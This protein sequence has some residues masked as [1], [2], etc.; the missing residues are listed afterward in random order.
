MVLVSCINKDENTNTKQ[1]N[2]TKVSGYLYISLC[3]SIGI[4]PVTNGWLLSS[5]I[6]KYTSLQSRCALSDDGL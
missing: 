1:L 6:H 2:D 4:I 3:H 5:N